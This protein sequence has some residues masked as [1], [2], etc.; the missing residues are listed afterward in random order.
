MDNTEKTESAVT[1]FPSIGCNS[2]ELPYTME[3]LQEIT[4]R[5]FVPENF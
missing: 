1:V 2:C 5:Y 4:L 3:Q